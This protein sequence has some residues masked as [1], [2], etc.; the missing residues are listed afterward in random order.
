MK[1]NFIEDLL[2][3]IEIEDSA[4]KKIID[5]ILDENSNDIGREKVN[6]EK[7]QNTLKVKEELVNSLNDKIK[8]LESTDVEALKK[9]EYEKGVADGSKEL[10]N[11]K[12]NMALE[13]AL[14]NSKAK[15]VKLLQKMIDNDKINY[16]EKDGNFT[17][18]GLDDQLKSIKESHSY[19]FEEDKKND[20]QPTIDLG[21]VHT[22]TTPSNN[23]STLLG[24]LH[25]KYDK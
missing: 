14:A 6:T 5:A 11:F 10:E 20:K 24:A 4:K 1:R 15:D 25:E 13:K 17:V 22:E 3:D 2:K 19:L 21:G 12:K 23:A 9:E 16:E 18:I 7:V 8:E